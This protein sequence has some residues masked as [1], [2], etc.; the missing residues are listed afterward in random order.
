MC[1]LPSE[2][3]NKIV[4]NILDESICTEKNYDLGGSK[5]TFRQCVNRN[6]GIGKKVTTMLYNLIIKHPEKKIEVFNYLE[7]FLTLEEKRYMKKNL[8]DIKT[9]LNCVVKKINNRNKNISDNKK[10]NYRIVD[11]AT[12]QK[13]GWSIRKYVEEATILS[14]EAIEGLTE[15]HNGEI[16]KQIPIIKEQPENR[17]I[18]LD[19]NN[20][21]IGMWSFKP[22]Y[23]DVFQKTK[24]GELFDVEIT[25]DMMPTLIPGT[26]NIYFSNI[27]LKPQYRKTIVFK[28]LLFSIIEL[29]ETWAD[30]GIFIHEI[31]AQA[32][33]DSGKN[34]CKSIGLNFVKNHIDHGEIYCGYVYNLVE[35]E[36]CRD[37]EKVK[38]LFMSKE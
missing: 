38:Y 17:R 20:K 30:E 32:Y 10:Q 4:V 8:D 26:Y 9:T 25:P 2:F 19:E 1:V 36:F 22:F 11:I 6:N 15:E 23:D 29:I 7:Q 27:C 16:E 14:Y 33:S 3:L 37:F 24:N 12:L 34:L 35:E 18:L 28:I 5:N 13:M 21:M 31:C